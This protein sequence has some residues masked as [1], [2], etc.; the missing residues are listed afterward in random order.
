MLVCDGKLQITPDELDL[1]R[2]VSNEEDHPP[3]LRQSHSSAAAAAAAMPVHR[4]LAL[5]SC[6]PG[7]E[8]TVT[9]PAKSKKGTVKKASANCPCPL[10]VAVSVDCWMT[11]SGRGNWALQ[12]ERVVD[13]ANGQQICVCEWG[14]L[15]FAQKKKGIGHATCRC[16]DDV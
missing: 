11:G 3:F 12:T 1:T 2:A 7:L 10:C 5:T 9:L 4:E 15:N 6:N 16:C 14:K 13:V 8:K